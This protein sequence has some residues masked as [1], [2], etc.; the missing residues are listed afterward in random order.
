MALIF[1]K[2][3]NLLLF[4]ISYSDSGGVTISGLFERKKFSEYW[5]SKTIIDKGSSII[6]RD[7][8]KIVGWHI[9]SKKIKQLFQKLSRR[10]FKRDIQKYFFWQSTRMMF[11]MW[12]TN[13]KFCQWGKFWQGKTLNN[14]LM[15]QVVLKK[16]FC[17]FREKWNFSALFGL[18]GAKRAPMYTT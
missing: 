4:P 17:V 15:P 2:I 7:I 1:K 8:F 18:F 12:K 3:L 6:L 9:E 10:F 14:K 5:I 13:S 16:R 11:P